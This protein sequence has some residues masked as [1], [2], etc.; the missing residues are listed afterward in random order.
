M[1]LYDREV[2]GLSLT[3]GTALCPLPRQ[4]ILVSTGSTKTWLKHCRP[5]RKASTET[6]TK[7]MIRK[8]ANVIG[9]TLVTEY[10]YVIGDESQNLLQWNINV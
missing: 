4:F 3:K 6:K 5:S 1:S 9:Y 8:E 10:M 2:A 7:L